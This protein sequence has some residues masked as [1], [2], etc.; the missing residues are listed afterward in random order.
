M[1]EER[2]KNK[3]NFK[4][5]RFFF[6]FSPAFSL[7]SLK[8]EAFKRKQT[9]ANE[10][11]SPSPTSFG[12]GSRSDSRLGCHSLRSLG[13]SPSIFSIKKTDTLVSIFLSMGYKKDI[14]AVFTY[15]FELLQ[16]M[17]SLLTQG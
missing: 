12:A 8:K 3:G 6:F 9:K 14:F 15:E 4:K 2:G 16:K 10:N 1:Q 17:K 13:A 11:P 5:N 7:S